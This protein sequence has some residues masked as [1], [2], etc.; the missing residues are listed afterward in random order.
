M[1]ASECWDGI[2]P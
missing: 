2:S 1:S